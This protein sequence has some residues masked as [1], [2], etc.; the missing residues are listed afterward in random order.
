[1]HW[2]TEDNA[3]RAQ[4]NQNPYPPY[5]EPDGISLFVSA[6]PVK[7]PRISGTGGFEVLFNRKT[8]DIT[9][10][11]VLGVGGDVGAGVLAHG[12]IN[13]VYNIGDDNLKYAGVFVSL[14]AAAAAE[15]GL[16]GGGAYAPHLEGNFVNYWLPN[17]EGSYSVGMGGAGGIGIAATGSVVEYIPLFTLGPGDEFTPHAG[18]YLFENEQQWLVSQGIAELIGLLGNY[19]DFNP[20]DYDW[21]G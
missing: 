5:P 9:F 21:G 12:Q 6:D 10:F 11:G 17:P 13:E 18:W 14:S 8:G 4:T 16:S 7:T 2:I 3:I 20:E 19:A 1:M 15:L